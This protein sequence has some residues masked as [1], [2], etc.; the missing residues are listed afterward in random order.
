M[1]V[2]V[3][4]Y[5]AAAGQAIAV[6]DAVL[7]TNTYWDIYDASAGTN[8]KVYRCQGDAKTFYVDVHDNQADYFTI[9]LWEGWNAG[10]H[11]GTGI[12]V[13]VYMRK[14]AGAYAIVLRDTYFI[15]MTYGA[16]STH[17]YYCGQPVLYD[18]S[19]NSPIIIGHGTTAQ[20][21]DPIGYLSPYSTASWWKALRLALSQTDTVYSYGYD[22]TS[23]SSKFFS[24]K[25]GRNLIMPE[26]PIM[27]GS[28][29]I[30]FGYLDGA[31]AAG[32]GTGAVPSNGQTFLVDGVL[33]KAHYISR[34]T[35][36]RMQ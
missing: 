3:G 27:Y 21:G 16:N 23:T 31:W 33:W 35:L 34:I 24:P 19:Q 36:V 7:V 4:T 5:T 15:Y 32:Y 30:L 14:I 12:N 10:T 13:Y 11:V 6:F 17:A 8:Q 28:D 2:N 20:T 1:S 29:N 18:T 22:T 26:R 25:T 9:Y